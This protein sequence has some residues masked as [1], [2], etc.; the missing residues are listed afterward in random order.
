M[1]IRRSIISRSCRPGCMGV[2]SET[3]K[4]PAVH[5]FYLI[6]LSWLD[7]FLLGPQRGTSGLGKVSCRSAFYLFRLLRGLLGQPAGRLIDFPLMAWVTLSIA[8]LARTRGFSSLRSS[9]LWAVISALG[10]LTK[11]P[12]IFFLVGPVF[13]TLITN[14]HSG[15]RNYALLALSVFAGC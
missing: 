9:L 10:M 5:L 4:R 11:A 1:C 8:L 13:W 3:K 12:F 14:R 6:L 7:A 2:P 15:K